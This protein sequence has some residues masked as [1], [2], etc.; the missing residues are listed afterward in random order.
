MA[1][2][3]SQLADAWESFDDR[4]QEMHQVVGG[5]SRFALSDMVGALACNCVMQVQTSLS[6]DRSMRGGYG[7]VR[8]AT[9]GPD[10]GHAHCNLAEDSLMP[11]AGAG[12]RS[13]HDAGGTTN[14]CA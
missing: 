2:N 14:F 6:M 1:N 9:C 12:W 13:F 11:F 3:D 10:T 7:R 5:A 4:R 8:C